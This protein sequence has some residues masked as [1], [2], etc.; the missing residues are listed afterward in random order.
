[1][2]FLSEAVVFVVLCS[3]DGMH[4][5]TTTSNAVLPKR[6]NN[7]IK[8]HK[9]TSAR[10]D[11]PWLWLAGHR[12]AVMRLLFDRRVLGTLGVIAL[13]LAAGLFPPAHS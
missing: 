4:T 6:P 3:S 12:G 7:R 9:R 11:H 2:E 8:F 5:M 1:M 10:T 13:M